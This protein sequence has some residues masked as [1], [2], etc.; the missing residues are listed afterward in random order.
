MLDL[1]LPSG[2]FFAIVGAALTV[3]GLVSPELRAPMTD[4]NVNLSVGPAILLFGAFLLLLARRD[5]VR[6][7][8]KPVKK[9]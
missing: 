6:K 7:A 9:L 1:R 4:T 5:A 2:I 8:E 3:L